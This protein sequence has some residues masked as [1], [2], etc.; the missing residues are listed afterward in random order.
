MQQDG[1]GTIGG[2]E[3]DPEAIRAW[4][5]LSQASAALRAGLGRT[6]E[7]EAGV[8]LSEIEVLRRLAYAPAER[9]RMR[10]L[11]DQLFVAQSGVTRI[12]DRLVSQGWVVREQPPD[13]R[14]TVYARLTDEGRAIVERAVPVYARTVSEQLGDALSPADL[15]DLRR[16]LR[17]VLEN[18]GAWDDE[19]CDP[20]GEEAGGHP[21]GIDPTGR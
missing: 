10:D 5:N 3:G 6:L 19:R 17:R 2:M 21:Q 9:L 8:G 11:A 14:R 16:V 18:L 4:L 1:A 15:A 12:I 13:D 20:H 7:A